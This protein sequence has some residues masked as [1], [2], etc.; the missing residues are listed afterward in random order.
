MRINLDV[1]NGFRPA[2][3]SPTDYVVFE[4]L[5]QLFMGFQEMKHHVDASRDDLEKNG[6]QDF[7]ARVVI[8]IGTI[9]GFLAMMDVNSRQCLRNL[10]TNMAMF[11]QQRG[12]AIPMHALQQLPQAPAP[13][14]LTPYSG[15]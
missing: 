6:G 13:I 11:Q 4:D 5:K 8:G 9:V 3:K 1:G 10:L 2:H 12:P 7:I 15:Y 14:A